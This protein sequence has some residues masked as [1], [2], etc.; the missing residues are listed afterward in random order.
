MIQ[1]IQSVYLLAGMIL[2]TAIL[3]STIFYV[4]NDTG[5][6]ILG[7]F[8]VKEGSLDVDLIPMIPVA[9]L[10]GITI[11]IQ[12]FALIKFKNRKLQIQ[13]IQLSFL[14]ALLLISFLGFVYYS[15]NQANLD[16]VPFI[17]VLHTPLMMFANYMAIKG[18]KKDS[19]LV[20][21]V[22]RLR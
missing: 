22:D 18:I 16:V 9:V 11:A 6:L 19:A 21:S 7:A 13:L 3:F 15:L 10:A 14:V 8:G 2:G 1:R 12:G 17:G 4:S 5:N 20:K